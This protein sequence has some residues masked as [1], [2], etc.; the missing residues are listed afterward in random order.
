MPT[1]TTVS[2]NEQKYEI[3]AEV[4][5]SNVGAVGATRGTG[6][7]FVKTGTG[8]YNCN[9][10]IR[11][12]IKMY[13]ILERQ[14][15]LVGSPAGAFWAKITSV[16]QTAASG[17]TAPDSPSDIVIGITLLNNAATPAAADVTAVCTLT[18]GLVFRTNRMT[19]PF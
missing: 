14:A 10:T 1:A 19:N 12:G 9:V 13:E 15:D 18:L 17:D 7:T 16:T 3:E 2:H 8:T 11:S 4:D 5:L 6:C